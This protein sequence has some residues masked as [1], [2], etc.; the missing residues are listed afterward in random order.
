MMCGLYD[1]MGRRLA[2]DSGALAVEDV[3]AK[4]SEE[5]NG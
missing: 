2:D 4:G 1:V 5:G 3:V